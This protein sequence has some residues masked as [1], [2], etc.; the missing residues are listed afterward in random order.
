MKYILYYKCVFV[1]VHADAYYNSVR[2]ELD[3]MA[4][5]IE[6]ESWS[7]AVDQ[8]FLKKHSKKVIKRQDVIY[9]ERERGC[10][11][12]CLHMVCVRVY[13]TL[14]YPAYTPHMPHLSQ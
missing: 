10:G 1:C 4:Q 7:L 11:H 3:S 5:D 6:V 13:R 12:A 9:G 14:K 2:F 8:H